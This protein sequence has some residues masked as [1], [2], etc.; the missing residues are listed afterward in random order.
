M[1]VGF[2]VLSGLMAIGALAFWH[3]MKLWSVAV[4]GMNLIFASLFAI[5]LFEMVANILDGFMSITMFYN[6]LIAFSVIFVVV[7]TILMVTTS[8]I[9]KVDLYFQ[10]KTD[11]IAKWIA[12]LLIVVGF[13][14]VPTFIFYEIMPEKPKASAKVPTMAIVDFMSKGSLSPLIS[15]S[16]WNTSS[17]VQEQQKRDAAVY[18]QT[19]DEGMSGWKFEGDSPNAQ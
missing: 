10:E 9:S 1:G 7:L 18:T 12:V 16:E 14:G 13:A 8:S 5:G 6:D 15:G 17:F 2:W 19:I 3:K 4:V 11:K